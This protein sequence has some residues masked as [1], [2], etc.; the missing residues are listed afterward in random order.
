MT[1]GVRSRRPVGWL[2]TLLLV[3]TIAPA[4]LVAAGIMA[5]SGDSETIAKPPVT[6]ASATG[7]LVLTVLDDNDAPV[8]SANVKVRIRQV[9]MGADRFTTY[10]TDAGGR[11]KF[12]V[13]RPTPYYLSAHVSTPGHAPFL[14]EWENHDT[15]DPIPAEYTVRLD[16]GRTIG[17]VVHDKAGKPIE[18]VKVSPKFNLALH[19]SGPTRIGSGASVQTNARGEW[20]YESLPAELQQ[21]QLTFTHA[22]YFEKRSTELVSKLAVADGSVPSAVTMEQG[23]SFGGRVTD[24]AGKPIEGATVKYLK[25]GRYSSDSPSATTDSVGRYRFTSGEAGEGLIHVSTNGLA[26]AMRVAMVSRDM[27]PIDIRLTAGRELQ[28]R[29]VGPDQQPLDDAYVAFWNSDDRDVVGSIPGSRGKTDA[30]GFWSWAHAPEGESRFA[31]SR[32]DFRYVPG[33]VLTPGA[34]KFSSDDA[35]DDRAEA[36]AGALR[37]GR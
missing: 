36:D 14:A 32:K 4:V 2:A 31:V 29:V 12:E 16:R 34:G 15:P 33:E 6:L 10:K 7:S 21:V 24:A 20:T 27:E 22:S 1:S 30:R 28:V 3:V 25:E 9:F 35:G 23:L 19:P 11:L 17:G 37:Q 26:P 8:P 18:G 13:P 5:E